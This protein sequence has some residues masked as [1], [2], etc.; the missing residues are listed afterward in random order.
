MVIIRGRFPNG[1]CWERPFMLSGRASNCVA[2]VTTLIIVLGYLSTCVAAD[3]PAELRPTQL[4]QLLDAAREQF[5]SLSYHLSVKAFPYMHGSGK[6]AEKPNVL[7]SYDW[8]WQ[9]WQR[10][11]FQR[12]TIH[13]G[14]ASAKRYSQWWCSNGRF[15][16]TMKISDASGS[17]GR[18]AVI[19]QVSNGGRMAIYGSLVNTIWPRALGAGVTNKNSEVE[20]DPKSHDYILREVLKV[21]RKPTCYQTWVDPAR[22][23]VVVKRNE[24]TGGKL[25]LSQRFRNWRRVGRNL[26]LPMEVTTVAPGELID[27]STVGPEI[28]VNVPL[29]ESDFRLNF[30]KGAVMYDTIKGKVYMVGR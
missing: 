10:R 27:R 13:G 4:V 17:G 22:G 8:R 28:K 29:A 1:N 30:P 9:P 5:W 26:W 7:S 20:W 11:C 18:R 3:T 2:Y 25:F 15:I 23:F 14:Y 24:S 21:W 12:N 6:V 19:C 16:W